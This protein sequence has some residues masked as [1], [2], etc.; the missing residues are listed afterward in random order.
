MFRCLEC[1]RAFEETLELI[2][3][4][5]LDSP[6]YKKIY[7]C[8]H[9]KQNYYKPFVKDSISRREVIDKLIDVMQKLN[10]FEHK[11]SEAFN[12]CATD[13]T[14]LDYARSELFELF[15][16]L[17]ANDEFDLPRDIDAKIFDMVSSQEAAAVMGILTKNIEED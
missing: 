10:I 12:S 1:R 2:D 5:G 3:P 15:T 4:I 6:P 8:P 11:I 13:G 14:E 9:C 17:A 7:V 16:V